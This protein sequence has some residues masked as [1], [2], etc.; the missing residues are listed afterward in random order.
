MS[1]L[2]QIEQ[3]VHHVVEPLIQ[4]GDSIINPNRVAD[5]VR[6]RLDPKH[7]TPELLGYLS[8]M[9]LRDVVRNVLRRHLDPVEKARAVLM[10]GEQ[11]EDMFDVVL[12]DYYPTKRDVGGKREGVYIKRDLMTEDDV[13]R[14]CA[15]ME[16]MGASLTRHSKALWAD[17]C[18]RQEALR[19][20]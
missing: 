11:S 9:K 10:E 5:S 15:R 3:E 17:F 7:D 18:D 8:T 20:A 12:Q 6:D 1:L 14:Q 16:K 13:K 2:S 4:H 19:T